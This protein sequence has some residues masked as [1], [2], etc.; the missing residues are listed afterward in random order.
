MSTL[1]QIASR[2]A[3]LPVH[4]RAEVLDFVPFVKPRLGLSL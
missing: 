4:P 3:A 1:S 2:I